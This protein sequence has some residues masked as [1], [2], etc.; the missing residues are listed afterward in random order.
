M[1]HLRMPSITGTGNPHITVVKL[2]VNDYVIVFACLLFIEVARKD[3]LWPSW[4][5][6]AITA[7]ECWT[8]I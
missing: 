5:Y 4:G 8:Q 6:K 3:F 2:S 7:Q 1:L